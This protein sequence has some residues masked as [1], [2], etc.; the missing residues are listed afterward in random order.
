MDIDVASLPQTAAINNNTENSG[1]NANRTSDVNN[2]TEIN[3]NDDEKILSSIEDLIQNNI[4]YQN[5]LLM[6]A[7]QDSVPAGMQ[8]YQPNIIEE[9]KVNPV[10]AIYD[11]NKPHD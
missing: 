3:N 6:H 1:E 11:S 10:K 8:Q 2:N 5:P 4:I 7:L 9:Y